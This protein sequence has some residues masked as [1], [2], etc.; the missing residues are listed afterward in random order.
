MKKVP[1]FYKFA[2]GV[3]IPIMKGLF[4]CK[5]SNA[6]VVPEDGR[7]IICSNHLSLLDP[8]TLGVAQKRQIKFMAKE[9]LFRIK[10]LGA[11]MKKLGAFPV[12]RGAGDGKAISMAE[13]ILQSDEMFGIFLEGTRSKTGE[14]LRPR[15]GAALI[16]YQT[17]SPV[18]PCC[19]T[20]KKKKYRLF[21]RTL[22]TFGQP[23]TCEELGFKE[24]TPSEIRTATRMIMDKIKEMRAEHLEEF[25]NA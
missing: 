8:M 4:R 10:L 6:D 18:V 9:E 3:F 14:F 21:T 12:V 17:N 7:C 22:V 2:K 13:Q 20:P 15:A 19:I 1:G 23:I 5:I 24:G 25:G 11:V 16:A